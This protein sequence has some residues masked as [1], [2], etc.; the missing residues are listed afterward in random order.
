[1]FERDFE[2]WKLDTASG[3]AATCPSSGAACRAGRRLERLTLNNQFQDLAIS[4]DGR[5]AAFVARGELWATSAK[6]GGD[7]FRVTRTQAREAQPAW[8]PDSIADRVSVGAQRR[9]PTCS[10]TIFR[11]MWKPN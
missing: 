6:D 9:R 8:A 11:P 7:A 10:S 5:K 4:P 2:I 3:Q 1:M